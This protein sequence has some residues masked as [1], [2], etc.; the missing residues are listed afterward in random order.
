[1]MKKRQ[2]CGD[3]ES[4]KMKDSDCD[5]Y[6]WDAYKLFVCISFVHIFKPITLHLVNI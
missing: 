4:V 1:M 2:G 5:M 6:G 3:E